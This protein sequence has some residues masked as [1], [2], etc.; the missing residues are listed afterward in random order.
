MTITAVYAE[1]SLV[2]PSDAGVNGVNYAVFS[3]N[4]SSPVSG[5]PVKSSQWW[6]NFSGSAVGPKVELNDAITVAVHYFFAS[7]TTTPVTANQISPWSGTKLDLAGP[8]SVNAGFTFIKSQHYTLTNSAPSRL[9]ASV[10]EAAE[11]GKVQFESNSDNAGAGGAFNVPCITNTP[12]ADRVI[13]HA[14]AIPSTR[15]YLQSLTPQLLAV[16]RAEA[17]F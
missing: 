12:A 7:S 8:L 13:V 10:D 6:F 11:F 14:V 15:L 4:V 5:L 17:K 3:S 2:P 9:V 16:A 1:T